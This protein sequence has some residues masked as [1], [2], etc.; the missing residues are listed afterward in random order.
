MAA[1]VNADMQQRRVAVQLVSTGGFYGAERALL[2]LATYLRD[3]G[4]DSRVVALEGPGAV[5]LVHHAQARGISAQ[6]FAPGDRM[7]LPAMIRR[8]RSTLTGLSRAVV[9]SHGYK[10]DILLSALRIPRR[11]VC[12]ATCHSW[13]SQTAKMRAAE[14]LD[15]RVLRS[16]DHVIAV[17]QE[18]LQDLLASG[19]PA[20]QLSRINNGITPAAEDPLKARSDIRRE[21]SV[22]PEEKLIVQIGRLAYSKCNH[23]LIEALAE[24][25][26]PLRPRVLLVGDGDRRPL[27]ED[28]ARDRG[29]RDR[30]T[31]CGYRADAARFL[32][33][34]DA[35]AL[36]SN[37]E[38]LPIVILEAM[39]AGCPI[40]ATAVGA[41]PQVLADGVSAWIIPPENAA[42]LAQALGH[43]LSDRVA[44]AARATSAKTEFLRRFSR[45][46]MGRC[47]LELYERAWQRRGW[48]T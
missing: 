38:G 47:Y 9:H 35:L 25:P 42:A 32:A 10:P 26:A 44:A 15:K 2:E 43:A 40:I 39:A 14:W 46:A 20:S 19:M 6:A 23:L 36:T 31:F 37:Q 12:M 16:F 5:D 48:A 3:Q 22:Q 4:W 18:I 28:L 34:A 1:A 7:A 41:I 30:V 33:A 45:D 17:S 27:L 24:L 11:L 8:L 21:F 13:Y 29:L